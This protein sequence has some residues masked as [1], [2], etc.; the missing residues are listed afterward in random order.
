MINHARQ[1]IKTLTSV[2]SQISTTDGRWFSVR[3]LPYRTLDDRIEGLVITF[4]D[5]TVSEN[6]KKILAEKNEIIKI[7]E[8]RF[9][10]LFETAKDGMLILNAETGKILA[11]NPFMKELLGYSKEQFL[12]KSIWEISP[13]NDIIGNREKFAEL[14]VKKYV[15]YE[16]L[17]IETAGGEKVEVEFISNLYLT[18]NKEIIQC[19][20]RIRSNPK[21]VK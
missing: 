5:I 16:N 2:D 21:D 7:S 19:Q 20:V 10:R 6:V 17:P 8:I 1:V 4:I 3:I 9:R 14:Q 13:L 11:V 18:D 15:R 12:E